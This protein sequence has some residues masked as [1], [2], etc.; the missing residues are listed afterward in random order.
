[1][2][3]NLQDQVLQRGGGGAEAGI[4]GCETTRAMLARRIALASRREVAE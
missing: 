3:R 1:M 4:C 2:F